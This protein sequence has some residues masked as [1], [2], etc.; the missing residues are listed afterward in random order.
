MTR[1]ITAKFP[2]TCVRCGGRIAAG[3]RVEWDPDTKKTQ[4]ENCEPDPREERPAFQPT[5][6]Q[7]QALALFSTGRSIAIEAGAGTGKTSTLVLLAQSTDR[8]GQ[9]IAFNKAIV[10]DSERKFPHTVNCST[11]H[12]LAYKS[13][14]TPK[15][16]ERLR[17]SKRMKSDEIANHLGIKQGVQL[18][19]RMVARTFLGG[20]ALGAITK[21]CHSAD[22]EPTRKHVPYIEGI[23]PTVDGVRSYVNNEIVARAVEPYLKKAWADLMDPDGILPFRHD[24]YLKAWQLSEPVIKADYILFDEAQD[25]NPVMLAVINAQTHAQIVWVGDSQQQIYSFTGA[26]NALQKVKADDRTYLTQSFRFGPAIADQANEVLDML[27]AELRLTGTPTITSTVNRIPGT[28]DAILT[29]TNAVAVRTVLEM[30]QQGLRPALVGGGDEIKRFAEGARELQETGQTEYHE[31]ACFDSWEDVEKYVE[32]D[33]QGGELELMVKLVNDFGIPTI[34]AAL[35]RKVREDEADV[36]ISTAHKSKGREWDRV[37]LAYD[38]PP[39]NA[40]EEELRLLYVA[41]TRA[42]LVLDIDAA[43]ILRPVEVIGRGIPELEQ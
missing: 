5:L 2:G 28:P 13:W 4:H 14:M 26:I 20:L 7:T 30:Q 35:G 16:A 33:A 39:E 37:Q 8:R 6:E 21:W 24:H 43:L 12:A 15:H 18:D 41:C 27:D 42:K 1:T 3:D 25:A 9:Y 19:G 31:L 23:D 40:S 11:A 32:E 36:I 29:R 38:F 34:L 22:P 17:N 10:K